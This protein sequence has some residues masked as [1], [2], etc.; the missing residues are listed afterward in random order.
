MA[1]P[2][3]SFCAP[4]LRDGAV[5]ELSSSLHP[6]AACRGNPFSPLGRDLPDHLVETAGAHSTGHVK[7]NPHSNHSLQP[8]RERHGRGPVGGIFPSWCNAQSEMD[9][10]AY[11]P[12]LSQC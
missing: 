1:D 6:V 11:P 2:R 7:A 3:I 8:F 9:L 5:L 10:L 12:F 4:G